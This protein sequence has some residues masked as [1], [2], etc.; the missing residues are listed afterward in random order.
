MTLLYAFRFTSLELLVDDAFISFRYAETLA[1]HGELVFNLGERVEGFSNPLWTLGLALG[2]TL[3]VTPTALAPALGFGLGLATLA[4]VGWGAVRWLDCSATVALGAAG[5]VALQPAW[6]FWTGAGLEAPLFAFELVALWATLVAL[7]DTRR[8]AASAVLAGAIALTRPEGALLALLVVPALAGC[9][10]RRREVLFAGGFV[11]AVVGAQLGFRLAYYG[12]W[13]P[14]PVVAKAAFSLDG[15][16]RGLAYVGS[17]ALREGALFLIPLWVLAPQRKE[18]TLAGALVVGYAAFV[19]VA[20][21]D[22]LYRHRLLAHVTPLVALVAAPGAQWLVD[23]SFAGRVALLAGVAGDLALP[24]AW[25]GFFRGYALAD[26]REWEARWQRVGEALA[27][28]VP[29]RTLLA[30]NVAG[31][32]PYYSH[33][34]TLDLL[35]L[36]DP[37]VAR[38][39][40]AGRGTGYAGHE[41]AAPGYVL[42]RAPD[43]IYLSVLDGIPR[44]GL[45][46]LDVITDVL[47]RGPLYRYTALTRDPRFAERYAPVQLSLGDGCAANVFVRRDGT[48]PRERGEWT[49]TAKGP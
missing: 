45:Q 47:R 17:Y 16:A 49:T 5:V 27:R 25:T 34:P 9:G 43:V 29:P 12:A 46:R 31:R 28:D 41:R 18:R 7:R 44:E 30:T 22:G 42:D 15:L 39:A 23:R 36:T 3:G 19:V 21:G 38:S 4:L 2:A 10:A 40:A 20:G 13:L 37:V 11:L 8:A 26:I 24:L 35:G 33:L 48:W 6:C 32:V 14:N 1:K